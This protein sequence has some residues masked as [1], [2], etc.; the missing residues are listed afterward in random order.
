[1]SILVLNNVLRAGMPQSTMGSLSIAMLALIRNDYSCFAPI[2]YHCS[3]QKFITEPTVKTVDLSLSSQQQGDAVVAI[4]RMVL[5]LSH[6][7]M[8]ELL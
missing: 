2:Q 6:D 5:G 3:A 1:M 8:V 7:L 4:E